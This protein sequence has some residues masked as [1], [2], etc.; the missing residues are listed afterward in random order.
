[1]Y[2]K[3]KEI[4]N[5]ASTKRD[6]FKSFVLNQQDEIEFFNCDKENIVSLKE[7]LIEFKELK[8]KYYQLISEPLKS[9]QEKNPWC[10][11]IQ[12]LNS[13]K[14]TMSV[15]AKNYPSIN[16]GWNN[17]DMVVGGITEG[18]PPLSGLLYK[19]RFNT[20]SKVTTNSIEELKEIRNIIKSLNFFNN[21]E[22]IVS[23]SNH[24]LITP[25][26]F[27]EI[28]INV[29]WLEWVYYYYT[30]NLNRNGNMAVNKHGFL[31]NELD[32][33][34]ENNND[35]INKLYLRKK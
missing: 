27:E 3:E 17:D 29:R 22:G 6:V 21:E 33:I 26:S 14:Y 30:I 28:S 9:I 2:I 11:D 13:K 34:S 8:E 10:K 35:I 25:Q 32:N 31:N 19:Q 15:M 7:F 23:A 18:L 5:L 4:E 12:P 20:R 1:M 24:F 16:V